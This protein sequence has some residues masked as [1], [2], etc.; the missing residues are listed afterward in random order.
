MHF[1]NTD[2]MKNVKLLATIIVF[3][4]FNQQNEFNA[5]TIDLHGMK[6]V[7]DI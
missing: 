4:T 5:K 3:Y 2:I 7:N 1:N 6:P